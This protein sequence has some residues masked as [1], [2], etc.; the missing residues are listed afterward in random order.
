MSGGLTP[1]LAPE[2]VFLEDSGR[3]RMRV[4]ALDFVQ[5]VST[6]VY[7]LALATLGLAATAVD[8]VLRTRSFD[9]FM[10]VVERIDHGKPDPVRVT[11]GR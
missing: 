8:S 11:D 3:Y 1:T 5:F 9:A 6:L 7:Y 2:P 4:F 10:T